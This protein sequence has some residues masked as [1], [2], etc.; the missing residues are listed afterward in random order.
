MTGMDGDELKRLREA[1]GWTQSDLAD[2]ARELA[3]RDGYPGKLKQQ[4][5]ANYEKGTAKRVPS[6]LRYVLEAL[7]AGEHRIRSE[8]QQIDV[9]DPNRAKYGQGRLPPIGLLGTAMGG[10]YRGEPVEMT[11]LDLSEVVGHVERPLSLRDDSKAYALTIMG[12]SMWP[13]FRPGRRVI[14]SPKAPI[15]IGDDVIVQ[16][17]GEPDAEGHRRVVMV[18][19]KELVRRSASF[20]ELRQFNPDTTFRVEQSEIA[21]IHKVA[22]ELF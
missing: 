6:W 9:A 11:E 7:S 4:S 5:I 16:L 22:G 17:L 20:V 8:V 2:A 19:I 13:R 10:E 1:K 15:A 3:L 18:L 12:D 21:S 14:V